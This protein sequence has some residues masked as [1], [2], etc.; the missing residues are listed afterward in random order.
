ML[1]GGLGVRAEVS[2][3]LDARGVEEE[4]VDV[5]EPLPASTGDDVATPGLELDPLPHDRPLA[6]AIEAR[7]ADQLEAARAQ[8]GP[9]VREML[10]DVREG[11]PR[12]EH[13]LEEPV[14]PLAL[15]L[16]ALKLRD[17]DC[18]GAL[19]RA[20]LEVEGVV[21]GRGVL[22]RADVQERAL[23]LHRVARDHLA[24]AVVEVQGEVA[25]TAATQSDERAA[26]PDLEVERPRDATTLEHEGSAQTDLLPIAASPHALSESR[27]TSIERVERAGFGGQLA[28]GRAGL[29]SLDLR[30]GAC[31]EEKRERDPHRPSRAGSA[32]ATSRKMSSVRMSRPV[33]P[34]N[35][36]T[37]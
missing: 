35:V 29:G 14:E 33:G 6:H 24:L 21:V 36:R 28:D 8:G 23:P 13:T 19:E 32:G 16:L 1:D 2:R 25:H 4:E 18:A 30:A 27:V 37:S 22:L 3:H 15:P 10:L 34:R 12:R 11:H 9:A 7:R 26:A 5:G 17:H 31:E 20:Q